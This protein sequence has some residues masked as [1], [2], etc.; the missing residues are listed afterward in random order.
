M[1]RGRERARTSG[2]TDVKSVRR[3][4]NR[5]AHGDGFDVSACWWVGSYVCQWVDVLPR[6]IGNIICLMSLWLWQRFTRDAIL[7]AVQSPQV[8]GSIASTEFPTCLRCPMR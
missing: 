1:E 3:M 7:V 5:Y 8:V 4:G 2:L 6:K